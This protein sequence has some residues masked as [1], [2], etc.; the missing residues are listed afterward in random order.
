ML[1]LRFKKVNCMK[2]WA[3]K[4][5]FA[6]MVACLIISGLSLQGVKADTTRTV[7][8]AFFPMD[9]YNETLSNGERVGMDVEYLQRLCAYADW[10]IEYIDCKTWDEALEKL[11]NKEVDLVGSAQFSEQRAEVFD[12]ADLSSGYTFGVIAV[13]SDSK[14]AYEDFTL[15]RQLTF[16]MVSSYVRSDEFYQYLHDNRV[17]SPT[18]KEFDSTDELQKALEAGEID[19]MVH[20]LTEIKPSQR[21]IGKFAPK[22]FYYISYKENTDLMRELN[23]AIADLNFN[24][25]SFE[26]DLMSKYYSDRQDGGIVFTTLEKAY[27]RHKKT[28]NVG[29]VD[30]F[31]PFSYVENGNFVGLSRNA[32]DYMG[33]MS[34]LDVDYRLI[35][36]S[37]TA[38]EALKRGNI[39][40]IC[41][42][43]ITEEEMLDKG[44]LATKAYIQ[45]PIVIVTSRTDGNDR[46]NT[47]A[48]VPDFNNEAEEA[49]EAKNKEFVFYDT[50]EECLDAVAKGKADAA[51]CDGYLSE[52]LLGKDAN[53]STLKI[54]AVLNVDH[55]ISM[56]TAKNIS[57]EA[58]SIIRKTMPN[59]TDKQISEYIIA[60]NTFSAV[61]I[62]EFVRNHSFTIIILLLILIFVG[63]MVALH[64]YRDSIKIQKLMYKDFK[65]D[66]W[67]LNYLTYQAHSIISSSN[68]EI[69][70]VITLNVSQ[71]RLY[72]TLYGWKG[73]QVILDS[74]VGVLSDVVGNKEIFARDQSDRFVLLLRTAN[75]EEL[76]T[77]LEDIK[78]QIEDAI[79]RS[80]DN[81]MNIYMGVYIL[82][83]GSRD[84][85][86][87]IANANT[88][89]DAAKEENSQEYIMYDEALAKDLMETHS[90]EQLLKSVSIEDNF[91]AY[92]QAKVDIRTEKI[93]GAEALVRFLDPTAG[94]MVRAPYYFVPYY[95][96]TG[97]ITEI[98]FFVM[99]CVC[100]MLRRRLD[101][102][103]NV[104]PVSCNFSRHN[105]MRPGFSERF[106]AVLNKYNVPKEL[107]EVEIT[108]TL[109]VEELQRQ[110]V[111]QNIDELN[112]KGIH[113]SIDDFG[114]GYSSLGVFEQIPASVIKLDR[115]FLLNQEDRNRQIAIMKGIVHMAKDLDAQVV[116]EGVEND[117]D[118]EIMHE[119]NAYVAQGYKYSKPI[120]EKDFEKMLSVGTC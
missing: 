55:E 49:L 90:R 91:V 38:A 60:S 36:D 110:L 113:L 31:Y 13:D 39:D 98:D 26:A 41:Y 67:N 29:Y 4:I 42:N 115:S 102:G 21:I 100:K 117:K 77:R 18:V 80:T 89:M 48:I 104:V 105:F 72:N 65:M 84:I 33:E 16:G 11:S 53:Y 71:F 75:E 3:K 79:Y 62:H 22:P 112:A 8:V 95:E 52:Y 73:G 83:N 119:I 61:S 109:I 101:E 15:F 40:L 46:L 32:I 106:E 17:N 28:L 81:H 87:A 50:Q 7:R 10:Q 9:G 19:A 24:E 86:A 76:K 114:S 14:V 25:P 68:K 118:V 88:A 64:M 63:S 59:I 99:E 107:V 57:P 6:L 47:V 78:A 66:V 103:E 58:L 1:A 70:S 94:G 44:L 69:Y 97:K 82:P 45:I 5:I 96:K 111:K 92:Y 120:P 54:Q 37:K 56:V 30:G 20:S 2:N 12:Y 108:E 27:I 43:N 85:E 93:V 34:G 23:Q 116:C 35:E 74:M 51:L